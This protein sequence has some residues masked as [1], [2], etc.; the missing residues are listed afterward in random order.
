MSENTS[1]AAVKKFR[2]RHLF[3]RSVGDV[4]KVATQPLMQQQGKLYSALLRDWAQIAGPARAKISR[5]QR[6]QFPTQETSG[7]TLHL[8]VRANMAPELTYEIEQLLEQCAR[9][10]GYRAITRI[11]IH[12]THQGFDEK[13]PPQHS[14]ARHAP[15]AAI[16]LPETLPPEMREA[17]ARLASHVTSASDKKK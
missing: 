4:V 1:S 9:Y 10:F 13:A 2:K 16:A 17:L 14:A 15:A 12:A 3:A 11:V 7:A 6:L 5:P 8:E